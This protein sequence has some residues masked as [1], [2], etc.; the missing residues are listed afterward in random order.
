MVCAVTLVCSLGLTSYLPKVKATDDKSFTVTVLPR[1]SESEKVSIDFEIDANGNSVMVQEEN[2]QFS[3][4][5]T[6]ERGLLQDGKYVVLDAW[7]K[8]PVQPT[9]ASKAQGTIVTSVGSDNKTYPV[10]QQIKQTTT[11]TTSTTTTQKANASTTKIVN[12]QTQETVNA[13]SKEDSSR[14]MAD[15]R[16]FLTFETATGKVF[17]LIVDRDQ[18]VNQVRLVTEVSEQDLLNMIEIPIEPS[19]PKVEE[20]LPIIEVVEPEI[21]EEPQRVDWLLYVGG[22]ILLVLGSMAYVYFKKTN[23]TQN[24]LAKDDEEEEETPKK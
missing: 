15:K 7:K 17:H 11:S 2:S 14:P 6:V 4:N 24:F 22:A 1:P 8:H 16:E 5:G 18:D 9:P 13:I 12:T 23:K 20:T 10:R 3:I 19:E 21:K